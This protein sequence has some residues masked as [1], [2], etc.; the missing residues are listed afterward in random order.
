MHE[1]GP[2]TTVATESVKTAAIR[3]PNVTSNVLVR[4]KA[5]RSVSAEKVGDFES[6]KMALPITA[7]AIWVLIAIFS[8]I[9]CRHDHGGW[10]K[11]GWVLMIFILP[12]IGSLIDIV[13]GPWVAWRRCPLLNAVTLTRETRERNERIYRSD[14]RRRSPRRVWGI[15][16]HPGNDVAGNV[17]KFRAVGLDLRCRSDSRADRVGR[18]GMHRDDD[19]EEECRGTCLGCHVGWQ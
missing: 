9:L 1:L 14:R 17:F 2:Q 18:W 12:V 4:I 7:A 16:V 3:A 11:A 10:A 5:I 6:T 8:D 15:N 19:P 13:A